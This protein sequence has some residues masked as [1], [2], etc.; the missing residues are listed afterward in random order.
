MVEL[1]QKTVNNWCVII[2]Y[3]KL[4]LFVFF[5]F[6]KAQINHM[7][8]LKTLM[9][10]KASVLQLMQALSFTSRGPR[11]KC[12][13]VKGWAEMGDWWLSWARIKVHPPLC[14]SVLWGSV[15]TNNSLISGRS[16]CLLTPLQPLQPTHW[17]AAIYF[18]P[19]LPLSLFLF[20]FL[21]L[22]LFTAAAK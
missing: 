9:H 19:S 11:G 17:N 3:L 8:P 22:L 14:P 6:K 10:W 7:E 4:I 20:L 1:P 2:T 5:L 12:Q 16:V 15:L 18:F 13:T 21:L